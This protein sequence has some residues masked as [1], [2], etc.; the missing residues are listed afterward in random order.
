MLLPGESVFQKQI[1]FFFNYIIAFLYSKEELKPDIGKHPFRC[2]PHLYG[3]RLINYRAILTPC[4][5]VNGW[6][7]G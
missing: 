6:A 7:T 4:E 3:A 5:G 2:S 1:L